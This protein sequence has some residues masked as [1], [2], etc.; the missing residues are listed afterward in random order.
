MY[1]ISSYLINNAHVLGCVHGGLQGSR[2][3][4]ARPAPPRPRLWTYLFISLWSFTGKKV[5]P[6]PRVSRLG[7]S[8][9]EPEKRQ[10]K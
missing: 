2:E 1:F 9:R 6:K 5:T 4:F 10:S 7:A 3:S 8:A